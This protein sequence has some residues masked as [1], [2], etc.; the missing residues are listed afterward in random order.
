MLSVSSGLQTQYRFR[1]AEIARFCGS[2]HSH[3]AMRVLFDHAFP[4]AL[5]H[6]GFQTQ[7]EQSMLALKGIGVDVEHVRW[8]DD[9]QKGDLIHYFGRP[10]AT[11]IEAAHSRGMKLVIAELLT[12]TGSR[13]RRALRIQKTAIKVC[14]R[15]LPESFTARLAWES[16]RLADAV[17]ALTAW[18]AE[19]MQYLFGAPEARIHVVPNGVEETFFNVAATTRSPWLVCTAT[20]TERKRVLELAE[21]AVAAKTPLWIIGKPYSDADSYGQRFV[22]F[23]KSAPDVLRYEG[24]VQD[25][26]KMAAIY[27][28][29]RGFVLLSTMESLSLSALEASACECPL[30]LSDLPWA[31]TVFG[32]NARYCPVDATRD[33]TARC[34]R[35][36]YDKAQSLPCP[37]KPATW[38]DV[39]VQFR[40]IY[41]A[42]LKTSR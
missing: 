27:R 8:W 1:I 13:S 9:S 15:V 2:L 16:Y 29:A 20:I 24:P 3:E 12:G 42:V 19:L 10:P 17:V 4:F 30:L 6:G 41:E 36:F 23:A 5:T 37:P 40:E 26:S 14:E 25:R 31:R 21:A 32:E 18:E 7:I 33:E 22:S 28:E 39:A 35:D 11:Y 34:L 38:H